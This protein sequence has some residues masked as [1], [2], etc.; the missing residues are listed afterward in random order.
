MKKHQLPRDGV[1][2]AHFDFSP[3]PLPSDAVVE[4][5]IG[6]AWVLAELPAGL[7]PRVLLRGPD[8]PVG[9]G[10]AL[11]ATDQPLRV[12]VRIGTEV[13][14]RSAGHLVLVS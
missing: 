4:A 13:I 5:K 10:G 12:R 1:E 2:Y 3:T 11:V 14:V 9:S 7:A 8:A 6:S